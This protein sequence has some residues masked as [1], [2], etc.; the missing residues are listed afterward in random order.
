MQIGSFYVAQIMDKK[1]AISL[2]EDI[3]ILDWDSIAVEKST[4]NINVENII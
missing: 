3:I 1:N 2:S 4:F